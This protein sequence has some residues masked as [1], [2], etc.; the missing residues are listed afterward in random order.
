MEKDEKNEKNDQDK[1]QPSVTRQLIARGFGRDL[2]GLLLMYREDEIVRRLQTLHFGR[3]KLTIKQ[4]QKLLDL[5]LQSNSVVFCRTCSSPSM[6]T[7]HQNVIGCDINICVWCYTPHCTE[8]SPNGIVCVT[9]LGFMAGMCSDC[10]HDDCVRGATCPLCNQPTCNDNVPCMMCWFSF[11]TYKEHIIPPME[12]LSPGEAHA[13][14]KILKA[15][16]QRGYDPVAIVK[17]HDENK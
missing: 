8:C 5:L 2:Y 16:I 4:A 1:D 7:A 12:L 11:H 9:C 6:L 13:I 17:R 14:N 15:L 10:G 3:R